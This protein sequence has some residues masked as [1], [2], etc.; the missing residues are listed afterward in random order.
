MVTEVSTF[1]SRTQVSSGFKKNHHL[2]KSKYLHAKIAGLANV[3]F[4]V[5]ISPIL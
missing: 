4:C 5:T 1:L 2:S 3:K